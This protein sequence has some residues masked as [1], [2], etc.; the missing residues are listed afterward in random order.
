MGPTGGSNV[1]QVHPTRRCNLQCLHCYS[2]SGPRENATLDVALLARA[3][4]DAAGEG[5][6][7]LSVSGG[8][9]LLYPDLR[10]LLA[11]AKRHGL[12][13][14]VTTNGML[15]DDRRLSAL[16]GVT[17]LLAI[18]LDG[19]PASHDRIRANPRA[20]ST[21]RRRLPALRAS[22]VPFGF[23]F[24]LTQHNLHELDWVARFA[25][26]EGAGLLQIHPLESVGRATTS[27]L[28]GAG[29]DRIEA[30]FAFLEA[31]RIRAES[32][33]ELNVQVDLSH[34]PSLLR[35]PHRVYAG[36][37]DEGGPEDIDRP[38]AEA[39][40]P[41]IVET[42]GTVVPLMY[43][44]AR[45]YALGNLRRSPLRALARA[46]RRDTL[47]RFRALCRRVLHQSAGGG[48]S[49]GDASRP[50]FNWYEEMR[51]ASRAAA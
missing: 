18:S 2:S 51:S 14:A 24:T 25:R 49:D 48:A 19:E 3:V 5:Y 23:I 46:W 40:S 15:L 16:A 22:G 41:L 34:G 33:G 39:I 43:G 45:A 36:E 11:T 9:P 30:S 29:P 50:F 7:V 26:D 42:D 17:D 27:E 8:E 21:M 6:D 13:T 44:F 37:L 35:Q 20:F 4:G 32:N 28:M 12:R 10:A 31:A 1:I 38:L 47:P